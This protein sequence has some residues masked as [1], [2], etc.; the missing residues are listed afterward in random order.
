MNF[1]RG[2]QD[3]GNKILFISGG[4]GCGGAERVISILANHYS[5]QGWDVAIL[6]MLSKE[7]AYPLDEKIRI[8]DLTMRRRSRIR[9][10]PR[11]L[12]GI[13]KTVKMIDPDVIVSFVARIN[14]ITLFS[15][16]GLH[17]KI[18]ISERN[19]P[20]CDGRGFLTVAGTKVLYPYAYK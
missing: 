13:R 4:M 6:L 9:T 11:W 8:I 14:I 5:E 17:K 20:Y 18:I 2:K 15:L 12:K 16:S 19:D 3:M 7:V 10:L 1:T